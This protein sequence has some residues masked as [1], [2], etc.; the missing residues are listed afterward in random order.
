MNEGE[1]VKRHIV[2][3]NLDDYELDFL[4]NCGYLFYHHDN[5]VDVY[6]NGKCISK[7]FKQ[8]NGKYHF[9]KY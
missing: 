9:I 4:L 7:A 6:K 3:D 2:E 5:V 8:K 1:L